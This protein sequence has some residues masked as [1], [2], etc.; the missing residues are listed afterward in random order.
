ML[1]ANQRPCSLQK[2]RL[3]SGPSIDAAQH[4]P[5]LALVIW[6][7]NELPMEP[8]EL[9]SDLRRFLYENVESYEELEILV[10]L[11]AQPERAWTAT[12]LASTLK[13]SPQ[14]V[15]GGLD[16]LER[17]GLLEIG[18]ERE[19]ISL[20]IPLGEPPVAALLQELTRAYES[21]RLS[22]MRQMNANAVERVRTNAM[23]LF[24]DAF[25]LGRKKDKDG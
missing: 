21:N 24:A 2:C 16:G 25:V 12:E 3:I 10:L 23:H 8:Q 4:D 18:T 22:V 20:K 13:L 17:R 9:S 14:I 1:R 7:A 15:D 5:C 11:G 6:Y 19:R